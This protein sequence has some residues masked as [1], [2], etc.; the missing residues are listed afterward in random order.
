MPDLDIE[1]VVDKLL[2]FMVEEMEA[3]GSTTNTTHYNF[4]PDREDRSAFVTKYP[5]L[6]PMLVPA[7]NVCLS[8]RLIERQALDSMYN[9][10]G[11]S[12]AGQARGLSVKFKRPD[13]PAQPTYHIGAITAHAPMQIGNGNT[14]TIEAFQEAA[15]A[16]IEAAAAPPEQKAEAKSLLAKVLEH[17]LLCSVLGG[18]AGGL[19]SG[20]TG[21]G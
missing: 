16:G 2:V 1:A 18:I 3:L 7:L 19:T 8:R 17:P 13:Q 9:Y 6:E 11:L 4:E 15:L 14:M 10:L 12:T 20:L 5:E 21:K